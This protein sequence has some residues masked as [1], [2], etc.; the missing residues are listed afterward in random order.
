MTQTA[1]DLQRDAARPRSHVQISLQPATH[2]AVLHGPILPNLIRDEILA[3]VFAATVTAHP[4][5]KAI[6]GPGRH[7]TYAELD[8]EAAA[9]ARGLIKRGIR[10]SDVVGLWMGRGADLLVAQIAIAKTGAAWL[11][12]DADAPVERIAVCLQDA[13]AKGL[14]TSATFAAKLAASCPAWTLAGLLA[15]SQDAV[16]PAKA[17]SRALGARPEDP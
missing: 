11:P 10:P 15:D 5:K 16:G 17:D 6:A 3:E 8:S 13:E 2:P 7:L 1:P 14:L 4:D 9:I 12:F